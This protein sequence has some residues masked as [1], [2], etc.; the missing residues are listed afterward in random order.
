M[1]QEIFILVRPQNGLVIALSFAAGWLFVSPIS[2][3]LWIGMGVVYFLHSAGTIKNDI[4]DRETDRI[5]MPNRPL[6]SGKIPLVAADAFFFGFIALALSLAILGGKIFFIWGAIIYFVGWLYNEPPFLGSH[7]PVYS[8]V[9]LA[10]YFT[11][12]PFIFGAQAGGGKI[13]SIT[14][15][16]IITLIGMSL[17]RGAT[18]LFKD[19]KDVVGDRATNKK[20]FFLEFGSTTTTL[21]SLLLSIVGGALIL[22]GTAI[23]NGVGLQMLP[24]IIFIVIG[25]WFRFRVARY[26]IKG[27]ATYD[28]IYS[29]EIRLQLSH[30]LWIIWPR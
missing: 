5:N 3:G 26:P 1:L 27:V 10:L 2:A 30:I 16:F 17:S 20:T 19:F 21:S 6:V 29:N 28:L 13:F 11:A 4:V 9:L 22:Y 15:P 24:A 18:S 25:I 12:I 23:A 7:R 14:V 8:I